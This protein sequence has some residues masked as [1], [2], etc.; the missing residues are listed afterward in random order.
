M[1]DRGRLME[2]LAH[3]RPSG[4]WGYPAAS[5]VSDPAVLAPRPE[6]AT[7][8]PLETTVGG[9][10]GQGPRKTPSVPCLQGPWPS[11]PWTLGKNGLS[12]HLSIG[13]RVSGQGAQ[14]L[15]LPLSPLLILRDRDAVGL[16]RP[17]RPL[18]SGS[19]G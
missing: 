8:E 18:V 2:V 1:G 9:I 15:G 5:Q 4:G 6:L 19:L 7:T 10:Q 13:H 11:T 12:G 3:L 14:D 17:T 16:P